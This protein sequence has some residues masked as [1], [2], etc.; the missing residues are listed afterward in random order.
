MKSHK[1][2]GQGGRAFQRL[3]DFQPVVADRAF[4]RAPHHAQGFAVP[5]GRGNQRPAAGVYP[6]GS[7]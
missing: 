1:P 6:M 7:L 2:G 3:G 5:Q 4:G